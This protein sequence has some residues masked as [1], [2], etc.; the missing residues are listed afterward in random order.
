MTQPAN[1]TQDDH[2]NRWYTFEDDT[3]DYPSITTIINGGIPKALTAWASR[4]SAERAVDELEE[5]A[6]LPRRDDQID[7]I[8]QA[9]PEYRDYAGVRGDLVHEYAEA[10]LLGRIPTF[11]TSAAPD[12]VDYFPGVDAWIEDW[13]PEVV[14]VEATVIS[15]THGYAGT[16]DLIAYLVFGD[17]RRRLCIIDFKSGNQMYSSTRYQLAAGA[18]ADCLWLDGRRKPI[19][20][21]EALVGVHINPEHERGHETREYQW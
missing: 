15:S 11:D 18:S 5:W 10:R 20:K 13:Q 12:C 19:P 16:T 3:N 2:G 9:A 21:I 1:A 4:Q 17:G 7:F 14:A 6:L 8:K